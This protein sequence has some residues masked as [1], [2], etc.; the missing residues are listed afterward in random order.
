MATPSLWRVKLMWAALLTVWISL[1]YHLLQHFPLLPAWTMTPTRI[2]NAIPFAQAM[3]WP[4]LSLFVMLPIAPLFIR[5]PRD[6]RRYVIDFALLGLVSHTVFLLLPTQIER[7][8]VEVVDPLYQ[9][10]TNTD[11]PR[12]ACPSLHASMTVYSALWCGEL[13]RRHRGAWLAWTGV[14]L[15]TLVIFYATI[16]TRQHVLADL[17]AGAA[18]A[19]AVF[20]RPLR[21]PLESEDGHANSTDG[22]S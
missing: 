10:V 16:A 20:F 19:L 5:E 9:F 17:I 15:W 18:L 14:T 8:I 12:N 13:S 22:H 1:P 3:A 2:D 21:T 4:Y 7:P 6:I 11:G